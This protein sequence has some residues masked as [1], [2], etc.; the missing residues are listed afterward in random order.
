MWPL[1]LSHRDEVSDCHHPCFMDVQNRSA[2]H[3]LCDTRNGESL[4]PWERVIPKLMCAGASPAGLC[5]PRCWGGGEMQ[6]FWG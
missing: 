6:G 3:V 2:A 4:V 5:V 1:F